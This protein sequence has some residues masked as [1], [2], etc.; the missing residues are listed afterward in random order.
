MATIEIA[1]ASEDAEGEAEVLRTF[2]T[3]VTRGVNRAV[4]NLRRDDFERPPSEEPSFW[5]RGGPEVLPGTYRVTVRVPNPEG[6]PDGDAE[7]SG[8]VSVL[9]DPRMEIPR[10]EREAKMEAILRAGGLRETLTESIVRIHGAQE[11]LRL[12]REKLR[13][14]EDETE[15]GESREEMAGE[16]QEGDDLAA[17]ARKLG[18]GL[19]ALERTLWVPEDTKGI[20][21]EETPWDDVSYALRSL[22]SSRGAPTPT[23]LRYLEI[24]EAAVEEATAEVDRFFAEDVAPFREEL[25]AAGVGLLGR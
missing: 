10:S 2:E 3:P 14:A 9:P 23:Q 1:R 6:G 5:R 13:Q 21:A 18:D 7:A 22:G 8:R 19:D 4:W 11:D 24:A 17:A 15:D 20:V 25:D 12:I 16:E